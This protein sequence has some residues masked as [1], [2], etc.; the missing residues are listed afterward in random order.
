MRLRNIFS[1]SVEAHTGWWRIDHEG[2]QLSGPSVYLPAADLYQP[3]LTQLGFVSTIDAA[4]GRRSAGL[5]THIV[6]DVSDP[7]R[8]ELMVSRRPIWQPGS[9]RRVKIREDADTKLITGAYTE[10]ADQT[11]R[12]AVQKDWSLI[13]IA[14]PRPT[15][16]RTPDAHTATAVA[17][18]PARAAVL[19]HYR[20]RQGRAHVPQ[21][22]LN[23]PN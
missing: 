23:R 4:A 21:L 1:P 15:L 5:S 6:A 14:G 20:L 16:P 11:W 9:Q 7:D 12:R 10:P 2:L 19:R 8:L 3:D 18:N 22:D 17:G 13:L